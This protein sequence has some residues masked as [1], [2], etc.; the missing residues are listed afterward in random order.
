ELF[1]KTEPLTFLDYP[2]L[3]RKGA[4]VQAKVEHLEYENQRLRQRNQLKEDALPVP[5]EVDPDGAELALLGG[6]DGDPV[7]V[8]EVA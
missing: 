7:S 2:S 4:V 8:E 5:D 3:E 6:D 1:R